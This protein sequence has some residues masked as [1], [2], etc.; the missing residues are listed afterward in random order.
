[1]KKIIII[2]IL[3]IFSFLF[4]ILA[5]S[6]SNLSNTT[7]SNILQQILPDSLYTL[8]KDRPVIYYSYG[9]YGYSWSLIAR[10]DSTYRIYSGRVGYTGDKYLDKI[11]DSV[12]FDTTK[13]II[14]INNL[15]S[16]GFDTI[17]AEAI[18]MKKVHRT[19]DFTL[20][21]DLS[22]FN[23]DGVNVF[24]S[25]DAIA[26]SGGDSTIFNAK[27]NKLCLIMWWLSNSRI[28]K[29]IPDSTIY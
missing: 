22:G 15:L 12:P 18:N 13:F 20:Y 23:S 8:L 4:S 28:R 3:L 21:T 1:M 10:I 16:W 29:Y 24:N 9:H 5:N 7:S 14:H 25:D 19:S 26:F 6:M 27:F 11:S 17:S 2:P